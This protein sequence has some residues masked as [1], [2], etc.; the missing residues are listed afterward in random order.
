MSR[1]LSEPE[2]ARLRSERLGFVFQSFNLLARTSALENVALPLFYAASGPGWRRLAHGAGARGAQAARPGRP[3]AQH[4]G[5]ALRRPAAARRHRARADQRAEPAARRRADRQSRYAHLAR[6]HGDADRAQPRTGRHHHR[7]HARS[8]HRRLCR[9]RRDHARRPD[10]VRR[11]ETR[12]PAATAG[13]AQAAARRARHGR[14]GD[15]ATRHAFW[16]FATDDHGRGRCRRSGATR[17]A[18]R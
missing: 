14:A 11:A 16:A 1:G 9:S 18:R 8:R 10:R 15:T 12:A 17:C 13:A 6:D 4:A 3:R 5:P 7:R 2:L